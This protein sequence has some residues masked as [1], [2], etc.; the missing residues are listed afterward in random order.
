MLREAVKGASSTLNPELLEKMEAVFAEKR[1]G[2]RHN[3]NGSEKGR[4][5]RGRS[6]A[7]TPLSTGSPWSWV[8]SGIAAVRRWVWL[9]RW[10]SVGMR[11]QRKFHRGM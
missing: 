4:S 5:S 6:C 11:R 7:R 9:P 3:F 8:V 10:G 2:R 1:A